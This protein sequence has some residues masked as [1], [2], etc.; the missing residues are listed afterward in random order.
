M[1]LECPKCDFEFKTKE[2]DGKCPNCGNKYWFLGE[3]HT[4]DYSDC[5]REWEWENY[6]S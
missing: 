3:Y 5:W 6:A 4:G 1:E 2:Y